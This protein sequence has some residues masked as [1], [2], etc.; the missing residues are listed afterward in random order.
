[1]LALDNAVD[2]GHPHADILGRAALALASSLVLTSIASFMVINSSLAACSFSLV[3]C[4]S[5]LVDWSSSGLDKKLP[6]DAL[7]H[8]RGPRF[9]VGTFAGHGNSGGLEIRG[10]NLDLIA[11]DIIRQDLGQGD[12]NR[13]DLLAGGAPGAQIRMFFST[14]RCS[15]MLRKKFSKVMNASGS[16]KKLV[17]EIKRSLNSIRISSSESDR[18]SA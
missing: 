14:S 1:M 17:T 3:A 5:S 16:R 11:T 2:H 9:R 4:N 12:G 6:Q 18:W 13:I 7:G 8:A 15:T 10:E